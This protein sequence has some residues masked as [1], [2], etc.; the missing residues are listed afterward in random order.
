[1]THQVMQM[2]PIQIVREKLEQ[3]SDDEVSEQM[4]RNGHAAVVAYLGAAAVARRE[5]QGEEDR[6]RVGEMIAEEHLKQM[7]SPRKVE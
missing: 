1:M 4:D 7:Q 5:V 3:R 6:P 2:L